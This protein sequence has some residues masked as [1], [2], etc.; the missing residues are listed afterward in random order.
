MD[1][2][3]S[4]LPYLPETVCKEQESK[5]QGGRESKEQPQ[6]KKPQDCWLCQIHTARVGKAHSWRLHLDQE[7]QS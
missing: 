5:R 6:V 1:V 2:G 3:L 4:G 7:N